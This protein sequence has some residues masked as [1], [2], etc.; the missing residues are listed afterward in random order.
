MWLGYTQTYIE[1]LCHGNLYEEEA[2]S[3]ANIFKQSL[4]KTAL[5]AELRPIERIIK[6]DP[7]SALLYT[8]NVKNEAEENSVVE[9]KYPTSACVID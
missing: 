2:L 5:P 3:I 6:L 9:V 4:V 7:G 1:A 8:A